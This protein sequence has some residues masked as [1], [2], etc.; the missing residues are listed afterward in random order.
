VTRRRLIV[1]LMSAGLLALPTPAFAS[2]A[3]P[4]GTLRQRLADEEIV[5]VG[6]VTRTESRGRLAIVTVE[7]VWKGDVAGTVEVAGG[8]LQDNAGSSVD[9]DYE[10][11][12]RYLFV[13]SGGEGPRLEDS[14]CTDTRRWK[15][16]LDRLRPPGAVAV[17]DAPPG[18][19]APRAPAPSPSAGAQPVAWI[20]ATAGVAIIVIVGIGAL[21][22]RRAG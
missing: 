11:G 1:L 19:G 3:M 20:L 21:A 6:T 17:S 2:C 10:D 12:R 16:R 7:S 9:R 18:A 4:E 13:P 5:F 14:I 8:V 15:P 22:R